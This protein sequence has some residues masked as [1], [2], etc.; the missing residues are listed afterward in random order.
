MAPNR[1]V[2]L[3]DMLT[4]KAQPFYD[5]ISTLGFAGALISQRGDKTEIAEQI[6][7]A[8]R[9]AMRSRVLKLQDAVGELGLCV[10]KKAVDRL[11]ERLNYPDHETYEGLAQTYADIDRRLKDELSITTLLVIDGGKKRFYEPV[12]PL[13]GKDADCKFPSVAYEIEQAGK[14]YACDLTT[15]SAFHSIRCLEAGIRAVA[16]CL[17]ISDPTKA[18]ERN[19]GRTLGSIKTQIDKR[20][21]TSSDRMHGDG[22]L[23]DEIYGSLA[24]IQNPYRNSTMHLD[25]VYTA[26]EALHIFEVVKGLMTRISSRMDEQGQPLA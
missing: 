14:C 4:F 3:W 13:F 16:R 24:A 23:F 12:D 26:P 6:D 2:S 11:A 22:Q 20:W 5:A 25:A 7:D 17:R 15:A 18:V 21:P 10:T 19:W 9:L 1:L 8:I